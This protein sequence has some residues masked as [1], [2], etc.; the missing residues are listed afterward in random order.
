[1]RAELEHWATL[2]RSTDFVSGDEAVPA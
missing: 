1:M 2:S